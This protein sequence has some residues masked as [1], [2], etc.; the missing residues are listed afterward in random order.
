MASVIAALRAHGNQAIENDSDSYMAAVALRRETDRGA[1]ILTTSAFEDE[2]QRALARKFKGL[3]STEQAELFGFEAPLRSFSAKIRIA[4]ALGIL[5]KSAKRI[6]EVI[7]VMRNTCAHSPMA[8][9]FEDKA[10]MRA[11]YFILQEVGHDGDELGMK[12]FSEE[13]PD[14]PRLIFL[15][16]MSDLIGRVAKGTRSRKPPFSDLLNA[17]IGIGAMEEEEDADGR[18]QEFRT[19]PTR[20]DPD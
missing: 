6:A 16:V 17:Y 11:L 3:N 15:M 2:L 13:R 20:W 5:D 10:L 19:R 8:T 18:H 12:R 7:R 4:Y 9:S 1:V 14:F